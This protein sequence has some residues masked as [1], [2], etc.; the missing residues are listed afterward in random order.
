MKFFYTLL[1]IIFIGSL[2]V[3]AEE[4]QNTRARDLGVPFEGN[5]GPLNSI[6]DVAGVEVGHRTVIEGDTIRT[7]I[8]VVFPLG[9][10]DFRGVPA[11]TFSLNGTGEM[12]GSHLLKE[13]G[14]MFG[15]VMLTNT[16]SIGTVR[17][18]YQAWVKENF[19]PDY[20]F[21]HSL[22]VVAETSDL[23]L[24]DQFGFHITEQHVFDALNSAAPGIVPEGNVGGGT[25][26]VAYGF[27]GGIGTASRTITLGENTYIIGVL[28]QAN[29]GWRGN[30]R[31]AGIPIGQELLDYSEEVQTP[32]EVKNS[33]IVVIATDMPLMPHQLER[34]ARRAAMGLGRP[35]SVSMSISGDIFL[36]F[37]TANVTTF[38][39][40]QDMKVIPNTNFLAL[41]T[42]FQATV[43]AT[44]E[45]IINQLVASESMEANGI[46]VDRLPHDE[47]RRLLI[48]Y[49]RGN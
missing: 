43:E 44:E 4:K 9:K 14:L 7:G 16:W 34:V 39:D 24:N 31:I 33:L 2:P 18:A 26:M 12:T 1:C 30:L 5:P 46:K 37:S 28:V 13:I 45:A 42:L 38:E 32:R 36:A 3:S 23:G 48:K 49:G 21:L 15:P 41:N 10:Q 17:Q 8:T 25:G 19:P 22:P 40:Q 20:W 29:H 35:G 27:K 11:A 6:T 47:L